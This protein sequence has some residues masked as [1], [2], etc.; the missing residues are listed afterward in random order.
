MLSKL[1]LAWGLMAFCVVVHAASVTSGVRWVR[2]QPTA[3]RG[4]WS[5]TWMFVHVAGGLIGIHLVEIAA[6][7]TLYVWR[8]AMPDVQSA[9]Y[10]SAVTYTT[11]GYGDVVL[12]LEWRLVGGIEAL[13]GILMC[14]L[15]GGFF[16]AVV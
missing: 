2:R 16:F 8:G 11:T 7:A 5:W 14:A 12:P 13:T 10:F 1:L 3:G 6:W 9:L 15:S 4:F